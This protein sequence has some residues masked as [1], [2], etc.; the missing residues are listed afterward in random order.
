MKAKLT[1]LLM[2]TVLLLGSGS[3]LW[4]Q[5]SAPHERQKSEAQREV[6][7]VLG[8]N[9]QPASFPGGQMEMMKFLSENTRYPKS[10]L[11]ANIQGRV[12]I[13]FVV[14]KDGSLTGFKI[15]KSSGN[16]DLDEEALRVARRMPKFVPARKMIDGELR[17]VAC[18]FKLP[19]HFRLGTLPAKK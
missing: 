2:A 4:A 18:Q 19:F 10:C 11:D 14:E 17:P 3:T 6:F 1:S 13:D 8:P 5:Q 15:A 16:S 12:Y 7:E 9:D